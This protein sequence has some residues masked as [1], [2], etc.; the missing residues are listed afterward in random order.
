LPLAALG[1][2]H[3]VDLISHA[4]EVLAGGPFVRRFGYGRVEWIADEESS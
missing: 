3:I 1:G 4:S 2:A